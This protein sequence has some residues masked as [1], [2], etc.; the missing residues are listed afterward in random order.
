VAHI[1]TWAVALT[2][3]L[4]VAFAARR[5]GT[6]T[7]SG[8]VAATAMGTVAM[9][10]GGDWGVLLLTYFTSSA[11]VSRFRAAD[12]ARLLVGRV[13]K[14]GPRDALQVVAN[15]GVFAAAAVAF[16]VTGHE[17][18]RLLAAGA[19]AASAA[20]TWATELGTLSRGLPRSILTWQRMDVG[21][22]GAVSGLGLLAGAA[23]AG[24]VGG[25][26][27]LLG[28]R[29][30][31]L[32]AALAGG[33]AGFLID[34]VL[35]ASVQVRRWC[36]VC[37]STTEQPIHRCG[38]VTSVSGGLRWI[39]NDGVNALSTTLGALLGVAAAG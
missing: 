11:L 38:T 36:P 27:T 4:T 12:K 20:D 37:Q 10:T 13:D 15:G 24:I 39:D 30:Q 9:G 34:S 29:S 1:Q 31:A 33:F 7:T 16:A 32:V 18:W 26:A 28:W 3:A 35:G 8:A 23:G 21:S 5:V 6:L 17:G 25:A 2:L 19:L 14:G 22:S